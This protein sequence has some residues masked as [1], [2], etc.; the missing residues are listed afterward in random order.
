MGD[1]YSFG[2]EIRER[3]YEIASVYRY[4]SQAQERDDEIYGRG[5]S[6]YYKYRQHDA[7][8][9]R[10]WSVDPLAKKYPWNSP[11]AFGENDVVS[12]VELEGLERVMI[13]GGVNMEIGGDYR[14]R[15]ILN[16]S[17]GIGIV[18]EGGG[19]LIGGQ[20]IGRVYSGG[21]GAPGESR[22]QLVFTAAG[23]VG[24][25]VGREME[26]PVFHSRIPNMLTTTLEKGVMVAAN[27][28]M[29]K[30][31]NQV[32][33]AAGWKGNSVF[34]S[35]YNDVIPGI[36][37]SP[38]RDEFETGGG[39]LSIL[40]RQGG[41]LQFGTEVF[42]GQRVVEESG[43]EPTYKKGG[44]KYY[45]MKEGHG[46][47]NEGIWYMGYKGSDF[48]VKLYTRGGRMGMFF[49]DMIHDVLNNPRFESKSPFGVGAMVGGSINLRNK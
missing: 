12:S 13:S 23:M 35:V 30:G 44:H 16:V 3:S 47:Y 40:D 28:V 14:G 37:L 4:G 8:L 22:R 39:Q 18:Y 1:Y 27:Y 43:E 9:G 32:V 46:K 49:Q 24:E 41:L 5:A 25:G 36:F 48:G 20:A 38:E 26:V 33:A 29:E 17:G 34:G 19:G 11:Y 31:R 10:F 45:E 7:R 15:F 21:L 2:A 6:Y 42:T